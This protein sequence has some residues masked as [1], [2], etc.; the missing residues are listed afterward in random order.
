MGFV[1]VFGNAVGTKPFKPILKVNFLKS[2]F[3]FVVFQQ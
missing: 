1:F 3:T 2:R